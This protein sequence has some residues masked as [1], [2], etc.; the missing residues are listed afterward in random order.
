[1]LGANSADFRA[2]LGVFERFSDD[3]R[4]ILK[5]S[6]KRLRAISG[7]IV[8]RLSNDVEAM[9][10]RFSCEFQTIIGAISSDV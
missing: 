7:A 9:F 6:S 10:K 4:M 5:R 2:I 3:F 8:K 1:M